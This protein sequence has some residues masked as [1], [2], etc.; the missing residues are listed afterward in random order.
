MNSFLAQETISDIEDSFSIHS[1]EQKSVSKF[2]VYF[3]TYDVIEIIQGI[4]AFE[5]YHK[6]DFDRF[7]N[8]S[9]VLVHSFAFKGFYDKIY[10]L[11]PHQDELASKLLDGNI[12]QEWKVDNHFK[13]VEDEFLQYLGLESLLK[14]INLSKNK[15][16]EKTYLDSLK[17]RADEIF[18]ADLLLWKPYWVDRLKYLRNEKNLL[19]FENDNYRIHQVLKTETFKK[20]KKAFDLARQSPSFQ[21]SNF[22][23]ALAM[24]YLQKELEKYEKNR[25]KN[26]LPIFYTSSEGIH[27]AFKILR[28]NDK[29]LLCYKKEGKPIPIIRD[30]IY[31]ILHPVFRK[32]AD[33]NIEEV[34]SKDLTSKRN[35]IQNIITGQ[36]KDIL[37]LKTMGFNDVLKEKWKDFENGVKELINLEFIKN[38]WFEEK[39]Y[40]SLGNSLD[41]F[42]DYRNKINNLDSY[43]D[44]E[45]KNMIKKLE[46]DYTRADLLTKIFNALSDV[47]KPI[48]K[49]TEYIGGIDVYRD[50]GL[51]RFGIESMKCPR[52]Q[53]KF[54]SLINSIK[55]RG[56]RHEFHHKISE[57]AT[58]L[59]EDPID[60]ESNDNLVIGIV[61]LWILEK[62]ELIDEIG[63]KIRPNYPRYEI[64]LIHAAALGML[65]TRKARNIPEVINCVYK[66]Q[67]NNYKVWIG[68]AYAYYRIWEKLGDNIPAL[69]ERTTNRHWNQLIK[70]DEY[71]S[72]CLVA[73]DSAKKAVDHLKKIKDIDVKK[74]D[75]RRR[76]YLYVLNSYIYY[77]S[78]T[79][80]KEQFKGI[81]Q[82]YDE[83]RGYESNQRDWQGRF[84]DTLSWYNLRR[85]ILE[86]N[87]EFLLV[88]KDYNER[89]R[90]RI[91]TPRDEGIYQRLKELIPEV[92]SELFNLTT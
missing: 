13:I 89:A 23:D 78:R 65:E 6:F 79:G 25:S 57:L 80:T 28:E 31:F 9:A 49:Y 68:K 48:K 42:R 82:L 64:A 46:K 12:A 44:A 43:I 59:Y 8:D 17:H 7:Q 18:K 30:S 85:A 74:Q 63:N 15:K 70:S 56:D 33:K 88:A 76:H 29:K 1:L 24:Y 67:K 22:V 86:E 69:P 37:F 41:K 54:I 36:Y 2:K 92:Q 55:D 27:K 5:L 3:D 81:K 20:I 83:F 10:M 66:K 34:F 52:I 84:Y 87:E 51:T 47:H 40:H 77:I 91:A 73:I 71:R 35:E 11:P 75:V 19:V 50:F 32:D 72:Y 26:S 39:A 14:K 4:W 62:Y 21:K 60:D 53:S 38:I 90:D 58:Y 61:I 45:S 16:I